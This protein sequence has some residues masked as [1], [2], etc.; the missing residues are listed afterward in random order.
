MRMSGE[1]DAGTRH[2]GDSGDARVTRT[3]A[4]ERSDVSPDLEHLRGLAAPRGPRESP[5]WDGR[6]DPPRRKGSPSRGALSRP[7]PLG[8]TDPEVPLA[9]A[10]RLAGEEME[11]F[12]A[13]ADPD[14]V[15]EVEDRILELS[16]HMEA[17]EHERLR[18]LFDFDRMEGWTLSG[19][20]SAAEWYAHRVGTDRAT[21]RE[22]VRVARALHEL[23]LLSARFRQG[24]LTYSHVRA[25]TRVATP[26]DEDEI[27]EAVEGMSVAQV[28]R[29]VR[30]WRAD[31]SEEML[32]RDQARHEARGLSIVPELD[33]TYTLRGC[34][35]PE[36]GALLRQAIDAFSDHLF[37]EAWPGQVLA[38]QVELPREVLEGRARLPGDRRSAARAR[39]DAEEEA[40]RRRADALVLL[41]EVA[42]STEGAQKGEDAPTTE[43]EESPEV[44]IDA[45]KPSP[46]RS[47]P[48]SGPRTRTLPRSSLG[49]GRYQVMLHVEP[50][51]LRAD[52]PTRGSGRSHLE[53]GVRVSHETSRRIACDA[54]V[55]SVHLDSDGNLLN[56]GHARRVVSPAMRRALDLRD[57]RCCRFPGCTSPYTEAHHLKHWADGGETS[58]ENCFSLCRTHHRL[59]HEGRW[60]VKSLGGGH[61]RFLGPRG[62]TLEDRRWRQYH[63]DPEDRRRPL[64]ALARENGKRQP[65]AAGFRPPIPCCP[66]P[67]SPAPVSPTPPSPTPPSPT[68]LTPAQAPPAGG[69]LRG[70]A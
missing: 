43:R 65:R 57:G 59:V 30:G 51:V 34:L 52:D 38:A 41:A 46:R 9:M 70:G 54:S 3:T 40:A 13:W 20:R 11:P 67:V 32:E 24:G 19:F 47:I 36:Q 15:C 48:S 28:E 4:W 53:D 61:L 66:A 58:L 37:R 14:R 69:V 64:E 27:L 33:G 23:P 1:G 7:T 35:T 18:L 6:G 55:V 56:L 16:A 21:A 49:A 25:L 31:S 60:Q 17:A 12:D 62:L 22:K 63:T 50:A 39:R 42:L 68:P 44:A 26:R 2:A 29:F 10:A 5:G 45:G 8:S